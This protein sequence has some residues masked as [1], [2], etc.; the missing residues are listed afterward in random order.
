MVAMRNK[1][2]KGKRKV[3]AK[4]TTRKTSTS[5]KSNKES[6]PEELRKDLAKLVEAEAEE[7][8]NAVIEEGKKGQLATVKYLFEMAHIFPKP[9]EGTVSTTDEESFAKTLLDRLDI[10]DHPVV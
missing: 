3:V 5:Q 8:A 2:G 10:P 9:P 6:N 1:K 4:Q 7:L